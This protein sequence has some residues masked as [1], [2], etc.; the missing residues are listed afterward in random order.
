MN[1]A[2]QS[3]QARI[4]AYLSQ[5]AGLNG[6][7]LDPKHLDRAL[8]ALG[9]S[10]RAL[11]LLNQAETGDP[12]ARRRIFESSL[13]GETYFFRQS[14]HFALAAKAAADFDSQSG[15][16]FRAWSAG[17]SSGEEA[18]SLS[19]VLSSHLPYGLDGRLEVWATDI[20]ETA[21]DRAR[22]AEYSTW[23][24][25]DETWRVAPSGWEGPTDYEKSLVKFAQHNLLEKPSFTDHSFDLV[26]CRNV[27]I[28][29][30]EE[31]ARKAVSHLSASL[32]PGGMLVV[33]PMDLP[34]MP[35]GLQAIERTSLGAWRRSRV[36]APST[37]AAPAQE[38]PSEI[39]ARPQRQ[40]HGPRE[41]HLE[42]I[43]QMEAGRQEEAM[44][45]LASIEKHHPDYLPAGR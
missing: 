19:H 3:P 10:Q 12:A 18:Y 17:C 44:R 29:L 30:S 38:T 21:L 1:T 37:P 39:P 14:E 24:F 2:A 34:F 4:A 32:K 16:P 33:G 13:T 26:F 35:A 43:H 27:L 6:R 11:D 42:A 20:N 8:K 28:Y 31:S 23:S 5:A 7:A 41:E 36:E 40:A 9:G 22:R 15:E 45:I 25:R